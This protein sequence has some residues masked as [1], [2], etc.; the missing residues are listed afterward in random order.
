VIDVWF[1]EVSKSHFAGK[2]DLVR[3][4]D[5]MVFVFQKQLD[6]DK[7]FRVLPKRLKKYGL[8]LHLEKSQVVSS[9]H[10]KAKKAHQ[11]GKKLPTYKFLGFV[12]YWG[13]TRNGYWRLK[14]TSRADRFTAKLKGLR[15]F[16]WNNLNTNN[17]EG[18]LKTIIRVVKGWINYHGISDNGRRIG[19]FI[20][21][22]KRTL[23][24]WFNRRGRRKPM[25]W[26]EFTRLL[27]RINYPERWATISM[28][29]SSMNT[30]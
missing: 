27:K 8:E 12:C 29:P 2:A 23:F 13:Q 19:G 7:F 18:L 25:S 14:Y 6:A 3:Y 15:K 28:F 9:G 30:A 10:S 17:A 26:L 5:D 11:E 22:S 1:H 4:C 20:L 16:L 21:K 24:S